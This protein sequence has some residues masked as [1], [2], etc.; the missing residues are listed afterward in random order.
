[1]Y[2][3]CICFIG[4]SLENISNE[5]EAIKNQLNHESLLAGIQMYILINNNYDFELEEENIKLNSVL[6][7]ELNI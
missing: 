1:M 5:L 3:L 7:K 4:L 6:K 2:S